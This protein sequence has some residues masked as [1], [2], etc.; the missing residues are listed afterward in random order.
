MSTPYSTA[1]ALIYGKAGLQEFSEENLKIP[2]VQSLTHKVEVVA[3]DEMSRIFPEKQS[4]MVTIVS[5]KG[6]FS[7]RVDFPKGEPENPMTEEEFRGRYEDLMAYGQVEKRVFE[8]IYDLV[9]KPNTKVSEIIK[10]L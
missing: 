7:E 10:E 8:S 4:A 3:D 5:D 9:N 2:I 6:S 1:V